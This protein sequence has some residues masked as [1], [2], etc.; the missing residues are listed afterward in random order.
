MKHKEGDI[1]IAKNTVHMNPDVSKKRWLTKNKRYTIIENDTIGKVIIIHSD[2]GKFHQIPYTDRKKYFY[3][4]Q[5]Y[6]KAKLEKLNEG[7]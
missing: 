7:G 1:L 3:T 2:F 6:R 5:E 4:E